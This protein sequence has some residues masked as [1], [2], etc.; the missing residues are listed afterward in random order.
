MR[1]CTKLFAVGLSLGFAATALADTVVLNFEGINPNYPNVQ[2]TNIEN[3]YNGGT[4]SAGTS[5][6]NYGITFSSNAIALCLNTPTGDCSNTSRG[7]YGDPGSQQGALDFLTGDQTFMDDAAGFTDGFSFF[8]SAPFYT[9]SVSA[10]SGLDGTGTLLAT[11]NLGLT[12]DAGCDSSYSWG[13]DYCP[14]VP[15]GVNFSG[16]AESISFA[17]NA[18]YIIFD[19]VTF[20]SSTP[21]NPSPTPE[22]SSLAML[23][24][25][26]G[27]GT[28]VLRRKLRASRS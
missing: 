2:T 17:G 11:I 13:A 22:P 4:S 21:G 9:G 3:F 6:T 24:T 12:T 27:A 15:I 7:G 1:L 19:D 14:F 20:G 16:T 23:L 26:A 25:A 5:G 18:D 10:Y 28:E 8:Y